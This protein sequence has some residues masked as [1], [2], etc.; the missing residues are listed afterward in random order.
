MEK[1]LSQLFLFCRFVVVSM[2]LCT[3]PNVCDFFFR[4]IYLYAKLYD[5]PD[6]P[7]EIL[8]DRL[9]RLWK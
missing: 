3:V 2:F 8:S 7:I 6:Q 5:A 4:F 1:K 9:V